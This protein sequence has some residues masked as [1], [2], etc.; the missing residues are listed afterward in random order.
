MHSEMT[1]DMGSTATDTGRLR[2]LILGASSSGGIDLSTVE[3]EA[4]LIWR[5]AL[6]LM[7]NGG[8]GRA[9]SFRGRLE[10]R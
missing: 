2:Y 4:I 5:C 6:R 9:D 8:R 1:R 7:T 10:R 3:V